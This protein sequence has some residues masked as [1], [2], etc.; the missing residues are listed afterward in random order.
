MKN[1][2]NSH[3]PQ[4]R[5]IREPYLSIMTP[6]IMVTPLRREDPIEKYRLSNSSCS[7]HVGYPEGVNRCNKIE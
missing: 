3:V 2:L 7:A 5:I 4:R 6:R 1:I